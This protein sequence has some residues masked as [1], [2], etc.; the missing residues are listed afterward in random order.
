MGENR[1]EWNY[2]GLF[3]IDHPTLKIEKHLRMEGEN[4][5]VI[6]DAGNQETEYKVTAFTCSELRN[7]GQ[8]PF[9]LGYS[10]K[11][12]CHL[13]SFCLYE[14]LGCPGEKIEGKMDKGNFLSPETI[15][16]MVFL[17]QH[18]LLKQAFC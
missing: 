13:Q 7:R 18:E 8:A 16:W 10:C 1:G 12:C 2:S 11:C 14:N 9:L 5:L 17:P 6:H 4:I 3:S 15:D